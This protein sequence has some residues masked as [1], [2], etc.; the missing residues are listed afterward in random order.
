MIRTDAEYRNAL[1]RLDEEAETLDRQ[2]AHLRQE[3]DLSDDE[4]ERA[5]QPMISFSKQLEEEVEVYER[6]KRGDLGELQSLRAI[7]RWLIGARIARGL[8]QKELAERLDV[9][10]S[11]VSR[12]ERNDY[13]GITVDRAQRI[14]DA[15]G[16]RFEAGA[17]N[18]LDRQREHEHA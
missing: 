2:R 15:L 13:H 14:M 7:G 4:M 12:D 16:V 8:T 18:V 11:Q 3:M 10:P 5:M 1:E 17:E 6:M 9:S